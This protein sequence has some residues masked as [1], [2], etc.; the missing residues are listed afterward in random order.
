MTPMKLLQRENLW[1][2][3]A[4]GAIIAFVFWI[5]SFNIFNSDFFW[6]VTAGK[7]IIFSGK[8]ITTDP[9]AYTR[10]GLPYLANHEW[11]AQVILFLVFE[12]SGAMGVIVL[13][14]LLVAAAVTLPLVAGGKRFW[15]YAPLAMLAVIAVRGGAVDRPH[16]WTDAMVSAFLMAAALLLMNPSRSAQRIRRTF[17]TLVILQILWV[18]LHGA[19]AMLGVGIGGAL[20]LQ[21]LVDRWREREPLFHP[22]GIVI[23]LF[24]VALALALLCSPI[25]WENISYVHTLLTDNTTRFIAEWQPL[26]WPAYIR[27]L[28]PFWL[29]VLTSLAIGR[30][31]LLFSLPVLIGFGIFSRMA[32][33]N[34]TIFVVATLS[35]TVLQLEESFRWHRLLDWFS[36]YQWQSRTCMA[37]VIAGLLVYGSS[38]NRSFALR[39]NVSGYKVLDRTADAAAFLDREK[40]EGKIFNPYNLGAELL[41]HFSPKRKVFVDGRNIDYGDAFLTP[42]I[43]AATDPA[44]FRRLED[45]YGFTVALIDLSD[46][47]ESDFIQYL[48]PLRRDPSWVPVYF[49]DDVAVFLKDVSENHEAIARLRYQI[50]TPENFT[51]GQAIVGVTDYAPVIAELERAVAQA[52]HSLQAKF[53]LGRVLIAEGKMTEAGQTAQ[54][55]LALRTDDY[56]PYQLLGLVLA[57][58]GKYDAA[59]Q[60]FTISLTKLTAADAKPIRAYIAMI[61]DNLGEHKRAARFR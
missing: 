8:L 18:N 34:E 22:Q 23:V 45:Q 43:A 3:A 2:A 13:R 41:Y 33:R 9:F 36:R 40:I 37:A 58:Q 26:A 48:E 56:R 52:P 46:A 32:Y 61:F 17:I 42:L 1:N 7:L 31:H 5:C 44:A 38:V 28:W 12:L 57:R 27:D 19:A 35:L 14:V 39:Y 11:L 25:G 47:R 29:A 49:D 51:S 6:H 60:A 24:P 21:L 16:L 53:L 10:E 59:E 50:L 4:L 20:S 54:E 15:V 30:R 55:A